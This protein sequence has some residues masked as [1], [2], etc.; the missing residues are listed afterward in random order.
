MLAMRFRLPHDGTQYNAVQRLLY[1]LAGCGIAL[2]ILSGL[3]IWKPVQLY[4]L[5]LV[6]GGYEMGRRVHFLAMSGIVA[7]IAVHLTLVAIVPRT[8]RLM[9]TGH[10]T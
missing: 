10:A 3:A 4:P 6:L 9:I 1:V 5:C 7:F 2:A 8:L